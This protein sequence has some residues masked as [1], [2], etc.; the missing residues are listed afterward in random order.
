MEEEEEEEKEEEEGA[1]SCEEGFLKGA[2][3]G[4]QAQPVNAWCML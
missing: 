4:C 1:E 3:G 2:G